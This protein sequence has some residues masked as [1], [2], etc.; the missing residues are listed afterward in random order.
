LTGFFSS[1]LTSAL[2]GAV[3]AGAVAARTAG[4]TFVA[5]AVTAGLAGTTFVAG[6]W[7]KAAVV[8]NVAIKVAIVFIIKFPF[9]LCRNL[10]PYIY[11]T[12]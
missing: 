4:T 12:R 3:A 2:A 9:R 6:A 1:F 10:Y 8:A 7:A 5:G 11:I